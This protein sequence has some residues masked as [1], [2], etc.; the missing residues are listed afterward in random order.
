MA[1]E[2]PT[3]PPEG[4][5]PVADTDA[6][7][8]PPEGDS[9]PADA[10]SRAELKKIRS[11]TAALRRR[12]KEA[13][14]ELEKLRTEQLSETEKAIAEAR[15]V[16]RQEVLG[17]VNQRLVAAEIRAAAAKA[18]AIDPDDIVK[19]VDTAQV[20]VDDQGDIVGVDE[21]VAELLEAK[22]HL[23]K[24]PD[25]RFKV[26]ADGG[27]TNQRQLTRED[28]KRMSPSQ[29][30]AARKDGQLDVLLGK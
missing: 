21:A 3:A 24:Q 6:E 18:A 14:A 13:E 28:L 15:N 10:V 4:D 12:T 5:P 25:P 17:E 19:L 9:Q 1:D 7:T 16:A 8:P 27:A 29:I 20:A 11:E 23:V 26:P 2:Q 30:N 22:P